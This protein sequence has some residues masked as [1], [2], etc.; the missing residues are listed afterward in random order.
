MYNFE[1]EKAAKANHGNTQYGCYDGFENVLSTPLCSSWL[2]NVLIGHANALQPRWHVK[3]GAR[4]AGKLVVACH[5]L[6]VRV[7]AD[8]NC[9][10]SWSW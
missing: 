5:A 6:H 10:R 7:L 4:L 2:V 1:H 9:A 3:A 8:E